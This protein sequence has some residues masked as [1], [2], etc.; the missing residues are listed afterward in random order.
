MGLPLCKRWPFMIGSSPHATI[1]RVTSC[2]Q[3][4]LAKSKHLDP[5]IIDAQKTKVFLA[6]QWMT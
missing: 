4:H 2:F 1:R 3:K 6:I 5:N